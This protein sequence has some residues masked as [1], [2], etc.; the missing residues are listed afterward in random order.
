MRD[1]FFSFLAL[2]TLVFSSAPS[3]ASDY[4]CS[5]GE[6]EVSIALDGK[7]YE[8]FE[9]DRQVFNNDHRVIVNEGQTQ[10]KYEKFVAATYDG[11]G[12][13]SFQAYR[14]GRLAPLEKMLD[15]YYEHE[16]AYLVGGYFSQVQNKWVDFQ[17][18][19]MKCLF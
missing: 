15:F 10:T 18:E 11:A 1:S 9:L 13:E 7:V 6:V 5:N 4:K 12:Q 8:E 2:S 17:Y 14:P 19:Q 3:F 16:G